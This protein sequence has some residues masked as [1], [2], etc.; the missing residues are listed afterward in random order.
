MQRDEVKRWNRR[1]RVPSFRQGKSD[2]ELRLPFVRR[3]VDRRS[4]L[5]DSHNGVAC[6]YVFAIGGAGIALGQRCRETR[7]DKAPP[8]L[9]ATGV[10]SVSGWAV[11]PPT[12]PVVFLSLSLSPSETLSRSPFA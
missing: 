10:Y 11:H 7:A 8:P 2:F 1:E 12:Y 6:F 4:V 3:T 9:P 5:R